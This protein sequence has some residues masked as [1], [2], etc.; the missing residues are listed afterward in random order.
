M[1][2]TPYPSQ[3]FTR[4]NASPIAGQAIPKGSV[5]SW[6]ELDTSLLMLNQ[7]INDTIGLNVGPAGTFG[8]YHSKTYAA[9]NGTLNF[10]SL[11]GGSGITITDSFGDGTLTLS[12]FPEFVIQL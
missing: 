8:V 10:Y 6:A 3:F 11:I 4:S 1:P 12:V 9:D 5:L 7:K 2:L